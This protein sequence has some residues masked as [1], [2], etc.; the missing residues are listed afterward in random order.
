MADGE[1][2]AWP[3]PPAK[4]LSKYRWCPH[5]NQQIAERTYRSHRALYFPEGSIT[6]ETDAG[7][8]EVSIVIIASLAS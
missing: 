6:V 3:L 7:D 8:C 4:R 2:Q 1:D 5:C